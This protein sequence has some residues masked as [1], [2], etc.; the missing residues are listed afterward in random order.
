ME[1]MNVLTLIIT[2]VV[3][4]IL[5]GALLGPVISDATTTEK[6]FENN[7]YYPLTKVDENTEATIVWDTADPEAFTINDVRIDFPTTGRLT[8]LGSDSICMRYNTASNTHQIQV[9]G[10]YS[11]VQDYKAL[12]E[13]AGGTLTAVISGGV[14]TVTVGTDSP[15]SFDLGNDAYLLAPNNVNADY[16]AVMKITTEKAYLL[17]DS[18]VVI[19]GISVSNNQSQ[20]IGVFGKGNMTDGIQFDTFFE[21]SSYSGAG[22]TFTDVTTYSE[23]INGYKDLYALEKY[24]ATINYG[25]DQTSAATYSYFIVPSEVVAEKSVHLTPGQISLMGAIPVM[26]IVALLMVAVGAI[27]LRRAD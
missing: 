20:A 11:G 7:G 24:T 16:V 26:V 27:A 12:T 8:I 4:V 15:K 18:E 25:N 14:V 23:E 13:S 9:F 5:T 1:K 17:G 22:V 3:G 19:C 6:T 10:S 21:G 2:L